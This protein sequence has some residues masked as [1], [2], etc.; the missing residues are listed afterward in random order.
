[1]LMM[2][3]GAGGGWNRVKELK[4]R[5]ILDQIIWERMLVRNTIAAVVAGDLDSQQQ[6]GEFHYVRTYAGS[7]VSR[8]LIF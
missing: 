4:L 1:M 6:N 3:G 8:L 2:N 7:E 5:Q